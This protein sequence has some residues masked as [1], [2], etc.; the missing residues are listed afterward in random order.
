MQVNISDFSSSFDC[1]RVFMIWSSDVFFIPITPNPDKD[2]R[3]I[4]KK[5]RIQNS[6]KY[7]MWSFLRK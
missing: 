6:V 4:I 1:G 7:L 5:K 3:E 2:T